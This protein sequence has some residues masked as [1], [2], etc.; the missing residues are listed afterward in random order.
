MPTVSCQ[1]W[2]GCK[3]D[4]IGAF[5]IT[6]TIL[7]GEVG[8]PHCNYDILYYIRSLNNQSTG[9]IQIE[10]VRMTC[11]TG[12]LSRKPKPLH[13]RGQTL[14]HMACSLV[15]VV[16]SCDLPVSC[17]MSVSDDELVGHGPFSANMTPQ[18][19]RRHRVA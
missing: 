11:P 7:R 18:T 5:V 8:A 15:C 3:E 9:I 4:N 6:Y 19:S 1:P 10:K 17:H 14:S 2:C 13:N 16:H 12:S